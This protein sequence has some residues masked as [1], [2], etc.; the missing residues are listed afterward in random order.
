MKFIH[1]KKVVNTSED[2]PPGKEHEYIT[3]S[4]DFLLRSTMVNK[5]A[6][7]FMD[8]FIT[9]VEMFITELLRPIL[10][11]DEFYIRY[12]I[13]YPVLKKI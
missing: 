2:I 5:H 10:G 6:A 3:K 13:E 7:L 1:H 12:D 11:V 8:L 9:R 4:Q